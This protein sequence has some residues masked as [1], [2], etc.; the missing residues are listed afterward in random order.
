MKVLHLTLKKKWFDMILSGEKEEEYR[1]IKK[2]WVNRLTNEFKGCIGG[3]FMDRHAVIS[4]NIKDFDLIV[5]RNGYGN[6]VP[7]I[8]VECKSIDIGLPISGLSEE[9]WLD[10]N[11]FIIKLGKILS[12]KNINP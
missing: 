8:K 3:D 4:F 6:N 1:E 11:V 2:Y 7:E 12:T 9:G 10:T 5:L